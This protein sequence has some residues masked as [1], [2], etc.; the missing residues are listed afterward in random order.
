M[1]TERI[2]P[3]TTMDNVP[4]SRLDELLAH[5]EELRSNPETPINERLFDEVE[6][7]LTG[8]YHLNTAWRYFVLA[9]N[10]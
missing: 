10:I 4:I 7:Q 5:L 9:P 3:N 8:S 6:L 2:V 1:S